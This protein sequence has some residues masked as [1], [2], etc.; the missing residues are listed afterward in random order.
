MLTGWDLDVLSESRIDELT[1]RHKAALVKILGV[2]DSTALVLYA[3]G[4]RTME[5]IAGVALEEFLE[6][7][8]MNK[9]TL[10]DV[11]NKA[12]EARDKG[13]VTADVIAEIVEAQVAEK[14]EETPQPEAK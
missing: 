11:H 2:E 12:C 10:T 7:P 6:L 8:G 13:V 4:Y 9:K 5:E 1:A 14:A 3:N